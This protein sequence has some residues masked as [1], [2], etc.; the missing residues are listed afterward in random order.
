MQILCYLSGIIGGVYLSGSAVVFICFWFY[1]HMLLLLVSSLSVCFFLS[2][3]I[4][5]CDWV[6]FSLE[7]IVVTWAFLFV[8]FLFLVSMWTLLAQLYLVFSA[9]PS[10]CLHSTSILAT[11]AAFQTMIFNTQRVSVAVTPL[12]HI[13]EYFG[14]N[15][16]SGTCYPVCWFA[17]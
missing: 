5:R 15:L 8:V 3:F 17:L 14:S 1:S 7:C 2:S 13:Q 10:K 6:F 12:T 9:P 16:S 11:T 4:W